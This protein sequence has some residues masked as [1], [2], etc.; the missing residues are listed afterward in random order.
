[1]TSRER[2]LAALDHKETDRIP[3]AMV[4]GG[5]NPPAMQALDEFLKADRG[6]DAQSYIDSFLDVAEVWVTGDFDQDLDMWGVTR[7]MISYGAGSYSEIVHYPLREMET[8][9]EIRKYAFPRVSD[10]LVDEKAGT[11]V[12]NIAAYFDE[13]RGF[14]PFA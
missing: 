2:V 9:L 1:M 14:Y 3:I 5:I 12:E 13:A 6:I 8:L 11:P 7:K 10:M 4:C